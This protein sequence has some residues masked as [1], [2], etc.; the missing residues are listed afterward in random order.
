MKHFMLF[1]WDNYFGIWGHKPLKLR[2]KCHYITGNFITWLFV[3]PYK[4]ACVYINALNNKEKKKRTKE[5]RIN[6]K[7]AT[8]NRAIESRGR[9]NLKE[10]QRRRTSEPGQAVIHHH[11]YRHSC[12]GSQLVR[13]IRARTA[14]LLHAFVSV[15]LRV[16]PTIR[17]RAYW[18]IL[19]SETNIFFFFFFSRW[20]YFITTQSV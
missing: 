2:A 8:L 13:P 10:K 4:Y 15:I 11:V 17:L 20:S 9:S 19:L 6:W 16:K 7:R 3:I 1:I 12:F 14:Y 18:I 5:D